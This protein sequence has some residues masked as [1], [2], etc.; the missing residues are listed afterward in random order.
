MEE[1]LFKLC[2]ATETTAVQRVWF[3][4]QLTAYGRAPTPEQRD[5][6]QSNPTLEATECVH[7]HK[8]HSQCKK[9]TIG[10]EGLAPERHQQERHATPQGQAVQ[11]LGNKGQPPQVGM[12]NVGNG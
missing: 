3:A 8:H 11:G 12:V 5:S 1:M 2:G 6:L 4:V 9:Q 10:H 7:R